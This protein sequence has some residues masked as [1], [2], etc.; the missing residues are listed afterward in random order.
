MKCTRK[1]TNAR[2]AAR[3]REHHRIMEALIA[4]GM[5]REDASAKAYEQVAAGRKL[6]NGRRT[7]I[8]ATNP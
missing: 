3:L 6:T 4:A 7:G 5:D 8:I 2:I 1:G